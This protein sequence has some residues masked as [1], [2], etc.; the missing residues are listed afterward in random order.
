VQIRLEELE[1]IEKD[2]WINVRNLKIET[3]VNNLLAEQATELTA[4]QKKVRTGLD[5]VSKDRTKEENRIN[6]KY[7]NLE[8]ELKASH[9]KE[10]MAYRGQFRSKGGRGTALLLGKS[11][12]L[13]TFK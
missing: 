9:D 7:H 11:K 12:L 13:S 6:Q 3:K 5:E 4:Y 1:K 10:I 8:R 2:N